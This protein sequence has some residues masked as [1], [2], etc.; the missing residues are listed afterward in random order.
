MAIAC[1]PWAVQV[2]VALAIVGVEVSL[3]ASAAVSVKKVA[4]A[5][6]EAQLADARGSKVREYVAITGAG[7]D[8][9]RRQLC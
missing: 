1:R 6:E 8:C 3:T 4:A 7:A 5:G 2:A 9:C